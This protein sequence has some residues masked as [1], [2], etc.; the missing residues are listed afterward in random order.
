MLLAYI[1]THEITHVLEESTAH[2]PTGVMKKSWSRAD[3]GEISAG[4]LE[5]DP[6]DRELLRKGIE[7]RADDGRQGS[8]QNVTASR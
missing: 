3:F 6:M 4:K 7:R 1:L 2:S 8:L 5:F